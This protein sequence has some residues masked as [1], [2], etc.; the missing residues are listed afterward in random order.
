MQNIVFG[1][2]IMGGQEVSMIGLFFQKTY[3][4]ILPYKLIGNVAYP[5]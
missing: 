5:M 4:R 2:M 3:V 1:I